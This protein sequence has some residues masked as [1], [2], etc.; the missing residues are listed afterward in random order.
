MDIFRAGCNSRPAVKSASASALNRC[1]SDTDSIVW[2]EEERQE[3]ESCYA[4]GICTL[5]VF[6][7]TETPMK[8]SAAGQRSF[9]AIHAEGV[10]E[11]TEK[12]FLSCPNFSLTCN[13]I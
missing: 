11:K 8:S 1:N 13:K 4:W 6:F 2:M 9:S 3:Q 12:R 7:Y 10:S 5:G